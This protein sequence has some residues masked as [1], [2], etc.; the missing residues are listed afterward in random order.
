MSCPVNAQLEKA[1]ER[2]RLCLAFLA[3]QPAQLGN[4]ALH[5]LSRNQKYKIW[6]NTFVSA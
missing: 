3:L 2:V 1:R 4:G 6:L 5:H